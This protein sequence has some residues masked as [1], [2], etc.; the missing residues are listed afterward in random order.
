M[1]TTIE[2]IDKTKPL[3]VCASLFVKETAPEMVAIADQLGMPNLLQCQTPILDTTISLGGEDVL[4]FLRWIAESP[5]WREKFEQDL[6]C[7]IQDEDGNPFL[8]TWIP[9]NDFIQMLH[10]GRD[11]PVMQSLQKASEGWKAK[12]AVEVCFDGYRIQEKETSSHWP[13]DLG[14]PK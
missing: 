6:Q 4:S 8:S 9:V 13:N 3:S 2:Q 7:I 14:S 10:E 12:G 11:L 5:Y 1:R